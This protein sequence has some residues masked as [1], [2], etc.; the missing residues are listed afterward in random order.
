MSKNHPIPPSMSGLRMCI[1]CFFSRAYT[2]LDSRDIY[3][4]CIKNHVDVYYNNSCHDW[5]VDRK[6]DKMVSTRA[7]VN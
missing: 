7:R 4:I 2:R 3:Y 1:D 5:V 6:N